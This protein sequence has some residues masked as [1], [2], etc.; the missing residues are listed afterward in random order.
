MGKESPAEKESKS[1]R[2]SCDLFRA[3]EWAGE[4]YL[5]HKR[6]AVFPVGRAGGGFRLRGGEEVAER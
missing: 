3:A 5:R 1:S 6:V 4:L 2:A